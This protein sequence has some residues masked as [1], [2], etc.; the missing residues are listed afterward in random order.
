MV[1]RLF[2]SACFVLSSTL[3][4]TAQTLDNLGAV[5]AAVIA[6]YHVTQATADHT[7]IVTAGD[8]ITLLKSGLVMYGST[9]AAARSGVV[10]YHDGKL[11]AGGM[12][13]FMMAGN[14][15]NSTVPIRTWVSGEKCWLTYVEVKN[16]G[17][18]LQFLSDAINDVRYMGAIKFPVDKKEPMPA[19]DV[20]L[21]RVAEVISVSAQDAA[22][23]PAPAPVA[24]PAPAVVA[25]PIPP[26]PPPPPDEPP[27]IT[28][29][30]TKAQVQAI[31]GQPLHTAKVGTKEIESF[32]DMK[33]TFVNGKV[34]DVQ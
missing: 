18:Y 34:T 28:L 23:A 25:V 27:A 15:S 13:K 12:T 32:K 9:T 3:V 2:L 30:Q 31:L 21:A 4:S 29:G 5:K 8:V 14:N 1:S 10:S 11:N 6:K 19:P 16:D 33:I 24:P 7:D 22:P 26:P 17:L 20:M